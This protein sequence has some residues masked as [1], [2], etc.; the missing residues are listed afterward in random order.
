MGSLGKQSFEGR[1]GAH[2]SGLSNNLISKI[3]KNLKFGVYAYGKS[4]G[5]FAQKSFLMMFRGSCA[6][7]GTELGSTT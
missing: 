4:F 3:R 5:S 1:T 6:V 7:P 2:K